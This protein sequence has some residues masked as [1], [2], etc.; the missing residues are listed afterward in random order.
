MDK[1]LSQKEVI[2]KTGLKFYQLEH[3]KKI[4]TIVKV[5]HFDKDNHRNLPRKVIEII[6]AL[7]K[8]LQIIK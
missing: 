2:E 5:Y 1:Y 6:L 4:S 8:I 7:L 3:I